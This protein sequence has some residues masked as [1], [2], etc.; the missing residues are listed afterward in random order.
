MLLLSV[1]LCSWCSEVTRE[2]R[3]NRKGR[4]R[5][6]FLLCVAGGN[7]NSATGATTHPHYHLAERSIGIIPSVRNEKNILGNTLQKKK[8]SQ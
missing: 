3:L 4:E 6:G 2:R 7:E 1:G 8:H 5:E